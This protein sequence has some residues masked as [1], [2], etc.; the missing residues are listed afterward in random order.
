MFTSLSRTQQLELNTEEEHDENLLD[1][2]I[3]L[4][5]IVHEYSNLKKVSRF[6]MHIIREETWKIG[7]KVK[8][9]L[10]TQFNRLPHQP[11]QAWS[12][13]TF[14][15]RLKEAYENQRTRINLWALILPDSIRDK[16]IKKEL[17][18]FDWS[19]RWDLR[20]LS[21]VINFSI[22]SGLDSDA[23]TDTRS[24]I[25]LDTNSEPISDT[26]S[27]ASSDTSSEASSDT[28]SEASSDTGS[29]ASS[30]TRLVQILAHTEQ[31]KRIGF[32]TFIVLS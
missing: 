1:I 21:P 10:E 30:D 6:C 22:N 5:R 4:S 29:E 19:L 20:H 18:Y 15:H 12:Q 13:E 27:E 16:C 7:Y 3:K 23:D 32:A 28:S 2:S 11:G 24:A 8:Q 14:R 31:N 26:S 17:R 25:H 9:E